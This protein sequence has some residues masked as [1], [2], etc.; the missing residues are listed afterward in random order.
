[1]S[2]T[3]DP[4][5]TERLGRPAGNVVRSPVIDASSASA[6]EALTEAVLRG[7]RFIALTGEPGVRRSAILDAL[8]VSL[9]DAGMH[10]VR[11][12]NT[13]PGPLSLAGSSS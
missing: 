5:R 2:A 1:M 13:A 3:L 10:I 8:V 11:V 7:E 9:A 4:V 6:A 12:R